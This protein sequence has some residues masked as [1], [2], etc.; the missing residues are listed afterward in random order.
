MG[1]D[2]EGQEG[3]R[4]LLNAHTQACALPWPYQPLIEWIDTS[5]ERP[6]STLRGRLHSRVNIEQ[7]G[8]F[9]RLDRNPEPGNAV[10]GGGL[11][12]RQLLY[13]LE[14][15]NQCLAMNTQ[16]ERRAF[17]IAIVFEERNQRR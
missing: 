7:F 12:S 13:R 5:H 8:V 15:V 3:V 10:S 4:H 11:E 6:L 1:C 14:S 17:P 16:I 9:T 2:Q